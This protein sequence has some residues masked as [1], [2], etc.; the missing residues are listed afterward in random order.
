[1]RFGETFADVA[2]GARFG[3]LDD[4]EADFSGEELLTGEE[5]VA[6]AGEVRFGEVVRDGGTEV[7]PRKVVLFAA[8]SEVLVLVLDRVDGVEEVD[9]LEGFGVGAAS[10]GLH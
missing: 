1:M 7:R 5:D 3:E 9:L 8:D 6:V 4:E 2:D 10:S